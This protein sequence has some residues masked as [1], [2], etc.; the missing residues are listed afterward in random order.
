[1]I[2]WSKY[3]YSTSSRVTFMYTCFI[4][5]MRK[6]RENMKASYT[7][8]KI[9]RFRKENGMTQRELAEK[10]HVT[11]KAIS[12]WERGLNYPDLLILP[13]LAKVLGT[14]VSDLL[15]LE[16]EISDTTLKVIAE[17]TQQEK[18]EILK[19]LKMYF[20]IGISQGFLYVAFIIVI[21]LDGYYIKTHTIQ[22]WIDEIFKYTSLGLTICGIFFLVKNRRLLSLIYKR[23]NKNASEEE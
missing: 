11:D 15:G 20:L 10:L 6:G 5:E 22:Y 21:A 17:L 1:M 3:S 2:L 16:E 4:F 19:W 12:K 18:K 14:S 13:E 9:L 8:E 7:G 23:Q